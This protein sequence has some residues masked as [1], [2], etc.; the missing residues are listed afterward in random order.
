MA[1]EAALAEGMGEGAMLRMGASGVLT[2]ALN[3]SARLPGMASYQIPGPGIPGATAVRES[4][5]DIK[6]HYNTSG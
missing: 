4:E 3:V 5:A 1:R 6:I 2:M